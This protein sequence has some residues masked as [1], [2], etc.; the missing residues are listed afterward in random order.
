M[1]TKFLFGW[2][3]AY[4][5]AMAFLESAVVIW[6]R[7]VLYPNG[8]S[9]PLTEMDPGLAVTE[10]IREAATMIM[11]VAVAVI[12]GKHF[13]ERF[14]W[15]ILAFGVWDIF[16]YIFLWILIGWPESLM[17]WDVLFLIPVTWTGPVITPVIISVL[18]I[19]LG[20]VIIR[21]RDMGV[22]IVLKGWHWLLLIAGSLIV[23]TA[24]AMDYSRFV[25]KH[26]TIR[27]LINLP[28]SDGLFRLALSYEPEKFSWLLFIAGALVI[29]IVPFNLLIRQ[30]GEKK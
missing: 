6:I 16:Y 18:M 11:L 21:G 8:F 26:Y 5:V 9:F 2:I 19:F 15:F 7:E 28:D 23:I 22:R 20:M 29:C 3:I 4:A 14:A 24:F 13:T 10:I 1:K 17:E 25:L 27:E 12:A 30:K